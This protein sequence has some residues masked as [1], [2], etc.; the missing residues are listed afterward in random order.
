M[1]EPSF[2]FEPDSV[3]VKVGEEAILECHISGKPKPN[4]FWKTPDGKTV[5]PNNRIEWAESD[6]GHYSFTVSQQN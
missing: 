1:M 6:Y 3:T 4:I 2:N 5:L